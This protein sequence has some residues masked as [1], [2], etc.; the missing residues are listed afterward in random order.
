MGFLEV[1]APPLEWEDTEEYFKILNYVRKHGVIQFLETYKQAMRQ[2]VP[3]VSCRY[4]SYTQKA[5]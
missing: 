2:S 3:A 5:V 1:G 4:D